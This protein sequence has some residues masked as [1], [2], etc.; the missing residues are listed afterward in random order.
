MDI[1]ESEFSKMKSVLR[2][3]SFRLY[4]ESRMGIV[5]T[6]QN[7]KRFIRLLWAIPQV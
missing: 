2:N 5:D 4:S 7:A 3:L 1:Q 6:I